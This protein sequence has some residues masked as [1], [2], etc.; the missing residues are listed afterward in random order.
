MPT[1]PTLPTLP[2]IH[3]ITETETET[4]ETND[5]NEIIKNDEIEPMKSAKES[6]ELEQTETETI[7]M[8]DTENIA[9]LEEN[10]LEYNGDVTPPISDD[11]IVSPSPFI[12]ATN[13]SSDGSAKPRIN[14]NGKRV[15][16][17]TMAISRVGPTQKRINYKT[18]GIITKII[19]IMVC[20][21]TMLTAMTRISTTNW[22]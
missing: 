6:I 10:S 16:K 20:I 5:A 4:I 1:H 12:G 19:A 11:F 9:I 2:N 21:R 22:T 3:K 8:T 15:S 13:E 7:V 14:G 17:P 18:N